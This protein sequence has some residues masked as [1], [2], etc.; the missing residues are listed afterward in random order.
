V[1]YF[2]GARRIALARRVA[3][4]ACGWGLLT[5]LALAV[6]MLLAEGVVARGLVPPSARPAFAL[7]WLLAAI[8]QPINALSFVTDGIHWGTRDYRYL[9]NAMLTATGL[10]AAVLLAAE[11]AARIDLAGVWLITGFWTT[12]R[13][14]F[15]IARLWPGRALGPLGR[16]R[17]QHG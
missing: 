8:A 14:G 7:P 4:I 16:A 12:L 10:A 2:L 13:A 15:G 6:A 5:G 17:P 9:R 1:G 11:D 3:R